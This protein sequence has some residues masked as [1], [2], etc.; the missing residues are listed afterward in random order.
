MREN[1][2]DDDDELTV[3]GRRLD[4]R[5]R[6][7]ARQDGRGTTNHSLSL[8]VGPTLCSSAL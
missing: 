4:S 8:S 2:D 6:F 7:V 1:K 5:L 3:D